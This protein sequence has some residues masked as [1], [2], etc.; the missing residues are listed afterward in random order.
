M[1]AAKGRLEQPE[2]FRYKGEHPDGESSHQ[3]HRL[4]CLIRP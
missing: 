3:E 1:C 2:H 4:P